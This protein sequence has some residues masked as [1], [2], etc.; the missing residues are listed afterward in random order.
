MSSKKGARSPAT[1]KQP[2]RTPR[3][4]THGNLRQLTTAKGGNRS[5]G[6]APKT[7]TFGSP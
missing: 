6:G 2:Y 4:K 3:L 5:D 1:K 7:R